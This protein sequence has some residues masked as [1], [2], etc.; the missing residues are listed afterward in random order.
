MDNVL[1]S[2]GG[3]IVMAYFSALAANKGRY[4]FY[5]DNTFTHISG[6]IKEVIMV[7]N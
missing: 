4:I 2:F 3:F 7:R 5:N 6:K 1:K